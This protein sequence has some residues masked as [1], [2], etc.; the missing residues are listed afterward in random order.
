V[1]V[2]AVGRSDREVRVSEPEDLLRWLSSDELAAPDG[3]CLSWW[4]PSHPGYPY[5]EITGLLLHL[6]S[7]ER[8]APRARERLAGALLVEHSTGGAVRRHGLAYTFDTAMALRGLLAADAGA[9]HSGVATDWALLLIEAAQ[10]RSPAAAGPPPEPLEPET[11]W[12]LAFGAHQAKVCGA[13]LDYR[14]R[15]GP[16]PGLAEA[17][18]VL[19][20]AA[21]AAQDADGR[22][23]IHERSPVTYT[24]SHCY[25]VEGLLQRAADE[26]ARGGW[27]EPVLAGAH[28]L[29]RAQ[30]PDG[31]LCAWHDGVRASGARHADA[32]AQ[33]LRIWLVVDPDRYAEPAARARDFLWRL[34]V[35]PRGLRYADDSDDVNAWA[36]IF[37]AQALAWYAEPGRADAARIV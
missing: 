22:F 11:R 6:L 21:L 4:N 20:G 37:A 36:T 25:A 7:L 16:L 18:Q 19:A 23:R 2:A 3:H 10:R 9:V 35:A 17:V 32:T 13:L 12:S 8:T 15:Y 26:G 34:W 27:P 24:H 33:A 1:D 5:P 31:G 14:R 28:W 30:Q 29:A